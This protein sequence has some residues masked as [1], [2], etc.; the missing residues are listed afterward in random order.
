VEI[1]GIENHGGITHG[2]LNQA[3][4]YGN[5]GYGYYDDPD[6]GPGLLADTL[7]FNFGATSDHYISVNLQTFTKVVDAMGG[8]DIVLPYVVDG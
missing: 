4:L 7:E 6:L 2:K 5:P 1:P 3:F 8:I